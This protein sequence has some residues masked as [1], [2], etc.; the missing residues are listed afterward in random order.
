MTTSNAALLGAEVNNEQMSDILVASEHDSSHDLRRKTV[1]GAMAAGGAQAAALVLRTGSMVVMARLL[2]P[3]DF[4]LVGMVHSNRLMAFFHDFDCR[5]HLS[6]GV[7]DEEQCRRYSGSMSSRHPLASSAFFLL[8]CC[9]YGETSSFR[10]Q[11][12]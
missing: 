9:A 5:W 8:P 10:Y 3:E 7:G 1:R 11:R 2:Y 4:G 12:C 6:S